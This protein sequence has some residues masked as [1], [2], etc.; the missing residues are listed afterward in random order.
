MIKV[1]SWSRQALKQCSFVNNFD[2]DDD[3][4]DVD[5]VDDG[6]GDGDDGDKD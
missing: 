2:H 4:G 5:D 1:I 3:D 6:N